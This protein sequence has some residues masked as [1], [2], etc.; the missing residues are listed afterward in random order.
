[1]FFTL[2]RSSSTNGRQLKIFLWRSLDEL[3][4]PS[5]EV[6]I[7]HDNNCEWWNKTLPKM[8]SN[9]HVRL[10]IYASV[11]VIQDELFCENIA[12]K[13]GWWC[14]VFNRTFHLR[15][16][17]RN[18]KIQHYVIAISYS[19]ST[20]TTENKL[21]IF[22]NFFRQELQFWTFSTKRNNWKNREFFDISEKRNSKGWQTCLFNNKLIIFFTIILPTAK[23]IAENTLR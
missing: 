5:S 21:F 10:N 15:R 7:S 20:F 23:I 11:R 19:L 13:C 1:M 14:S 6:F 18:D 8:A 17:W 2:G 9:K 3:L 12:Q 16:R 22:N 4:H